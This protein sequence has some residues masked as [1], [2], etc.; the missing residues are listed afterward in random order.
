MDKYTVIINETLSKSF[1]VEAESYSE[2]IQKVKDKY[3]SEDPD[4][5]LSADDYYETDFDC[6]KNKNDIC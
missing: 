3:Y 5:I 1:D 4:Y 6:I 2:A